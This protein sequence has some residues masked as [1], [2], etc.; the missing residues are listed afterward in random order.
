MHTIAELKRIVEEVRHEL[1]GRTE[2]IR[3]LYDSEIEETQDKLR[4]TKIGFY[5]GDN[6]VLGKTLPIT[7]LIELNWR[8]LL[9]MSLEQQ[10]EIVIHEFFHVISYVKF[11]KQVGHRA[12]FKRLVRMYGYPA[13]IGM[14]TIE[15]E[16]HDSHW[17]YKIVCDKCG[18]VLG[19]R[20]KKSNLSR[21]VSTCCKSEIV[22]IENEGE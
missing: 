14:A 18:R 8:T 17:R 3:E 7:N 12:P 10:R 1:I 15:V 16:N 19:Y 6:E 5:N 4:A 20:N 21:Y 11:K 2:E 22:F 13:R 9:K